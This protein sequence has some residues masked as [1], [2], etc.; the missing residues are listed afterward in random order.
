MRSQAGREKVFN[1]SVRAQCEAGMLW[2]RNEAHRIENLDN[3][4]PNDG[5]LGNIEE[6]QDFEKTP[7]L[8]GGDVVGL[9]PNMDIISTAELSARALEESDINWRGIDYIWLSIYLFLVLG[10]VTMVNLGLGACVPV[11]LFK[12]KARSLSSLQNRD[13]GNW[14]LDTDSITINTTCYSF[15]GDIFR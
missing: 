2:R 6:M 13:K 14:W 8:V 5:A 15:G 12:S 9:Y 4:V 7:I 3:H 10:P 11:R 1:D